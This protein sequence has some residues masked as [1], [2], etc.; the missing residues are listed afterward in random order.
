L[1]EHFH[2]ALITFIFSQVQGDYCLS[3]NKSNKRLEE[4]YE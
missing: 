2:T 4:K 1:V 3:T